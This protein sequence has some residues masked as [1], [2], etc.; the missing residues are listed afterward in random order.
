VAAQ[1]TLV[2]RSIHFITEQTMERPDHYGVHRTRRASASPG[3]LRERVTVIHVR[4]LARLISEAI[5]D[6]PPLRLDV[7]L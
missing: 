7:S 6:D 1:I 4:G 3:H 2:V 5:N